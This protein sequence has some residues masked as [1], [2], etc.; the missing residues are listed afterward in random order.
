MTLCHRPLPVAVAALAATALTVPATAAQSTAPAPE[1]AGGCTSSVP[2]T[3]GEGGYAVYRIPAVVRASGGTLVAF[4]EAR[5][6]RSDA[7]SIDIVR[8]RSDDGGCTWGPQAIV[9]DQGANTIGNPAPVVD[10]ESGDLVLLSTRN[11]GDATE[12]EILRGEV[13]A[14]DSRRVFVQRSRDDGRTFGPL[15]EITDTTKRADWRWY[16]TGPGHA[17][18]LTRGEQEGRLV[19]PANHSSAPPAGS[20]DTGEEDK[21]YGAHSL[22]SDDGGRTWRIGFSDDTAEGV[23][24]TNESTA[25][26]LRDGSVYFNTRDQN[27]T[28]PETRADG[29]SRDGGETL[30]SP[31]APQPGLVGPVVQGS[32]LQVRGSGWPLLYSGPSDPTRRAGMAIRVSEDGGRS[33]DNRYPVSSAPAAYSDLVQLPDERIG[34][35]YETGVSDTYETITFVRS[36]IDQVIR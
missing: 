21:Y 9:A 35:L 28:S 24:N 32:V 33:W 16:A 15:H 13:P 30:A 36:R 1:R 34:L 11:A 25:A 17:I 4:A 31:Y 27:G 6:S 23:L 18:A 5:E 26:E 12:D 22:Y 19:V 8:R 29:V 10:P 7:G 2:F 3:S 20:P 14:A